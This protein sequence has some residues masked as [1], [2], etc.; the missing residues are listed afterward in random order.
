MHGLGFGKIIDVGLTGETAEIG[1]F[2][3]IS[4]YRFLESLIR[5]NPKILA[6]RIVIAINT[7]GAGRANEAA[8]TVFAYKIGAVQLVIPNTSFHIHETAARVI[9]VQ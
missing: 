4:F 5:G 3:R 2:A 9:A 7:Y 6:K 1:L 8:E